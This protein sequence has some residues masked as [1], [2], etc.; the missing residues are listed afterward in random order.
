MTVYAAEYLCPKDERTNIMKKTRN[1][2]SIHHYDASW[3]E[4][5]WLKWRKIRYRRAKLTYIIKTPNRILIRL[6]GDERYGKL[7]KLLKK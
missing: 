2:V 6:L 7:K 4:K 1:T 3:F 5:D